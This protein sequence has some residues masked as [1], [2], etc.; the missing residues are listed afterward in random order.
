[1]S[2]LLTQFLLPALVTGLF[3][4]SAT[5]VAI[6]VSL[7]GERKLFQ[8]ELAARFEQWQQQIAQELAKTPNGGPVAAARSI[9]PAAAPVRSAAPARPAAAPGPSRVAAIPQQQQSGAY[10]YAGDPD[11][12]LRRQFIP[13]GAK[14]RIGRSPECDIV[15]E[16][17]TAM[18]KM[19]ALIEMADGQVW[20]ADLG[21]RNGTFINGE[22]VRARAAVPD[23]ATLSFGGIEARLVRI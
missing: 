8:Q 19:H 11:S 18:S 14:M 9:K 10:L 13:I 7:R 23:L 3:A 2:S 21:S 1:M 4:A 5:I 17:A 20:L 6:K 15:F 22:R 16:A 12:A